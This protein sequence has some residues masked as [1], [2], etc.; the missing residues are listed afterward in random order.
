M[1]EINYQIRR[2][3]QRLAGVGPF[4]VIIWSPWYF[5][6]CRYGQLG[7]GGL[8]QLPSLGSLLRVAGLIR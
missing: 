4:K 8:L 6:L 3:L 7:W 2:K 5:I 1:P